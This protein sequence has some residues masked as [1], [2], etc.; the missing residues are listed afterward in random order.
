MSVTNVLGCNNIK[1]LMKTILVAQSLK[2]FGVSGNYICKIENLQFF[3][4]IALYPL[5][6]HDQW[7]LP[8]PTKNIVVDAE[9]NIMRAIASR[10]IATGISPHFV[11]ILAVAR[12][13]D[14]SQY[15]IDANRC[16]QQLLGNIAADDYPQSLFCSFSD[17]IA[18]NHAIDKFALIFSELCDMSIRD[19]FARYMPLFPTTR[20]T[21]ISGM[22]FQI[23][24]SLAAINRV[25]PTFRHGDMLAHNIMIKLTDDGDKYANGTHYLQYRI[26]DKIWNVPFFG[27]Y[28]KI[29][30][31]GHSEIPEE[32]IISSIQ[33][34]GNIWILDH[35][36]FITSF[37]SMAAELKYVSPELQ[38]LFNNLNPLQLS[39]NTS[40]L[41]LSQLAS[42]FPKP[43]DALQR[44]FFDQFSTDVNKELIIHQYTSPSANT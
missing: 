32:G 43:L 6:P 26:D 7:K 14:V 20:D 24:Y 29:I 1:N 35:I 13:T 23:Y 12:C 11:E 41:K 36:A 44:G 22:I 27:I 28:I 2:T 30:D 38:K 34:P 17:L 37:Q 3:V 31:F 25:W 19:Y 33:R 4:K 16:N 39:S 5:F 42:S 10:I 40:P 8:P 21:L 18:T 9:I 15:I